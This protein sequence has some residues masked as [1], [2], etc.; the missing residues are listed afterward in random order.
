[1]VVESFTA[2]WWLAQ[3]SIENVVAL[4]GAS[5]STAQAEFILKLVPEDGRIWLFPDGDPAGE[6]LAESALKLISPHRLVRWIKL[7]DGKQPT[8]MSREELH[9]LLP[10]I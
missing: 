2:V 9:T 7:N 5:C 8:D 10:L 6:R 3:E 1:V 4:M